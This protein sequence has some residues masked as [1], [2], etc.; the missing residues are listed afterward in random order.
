MNVQFNGKSRFDGDGGR[1]RLLDAIK[2]QRLALGR[3]ELVVALADAGEIQDVKVGAKLV[4]QDD[5][6]TDVYFILLG[7]FD[8][9]VNGVKVNE[10]G[11]GVH[12][13]EVAGID[14]G[15]KRSATL[16][17]TEPSVVFKLPD[18]QIRKL[19]KQHPEMFA[20][21]ALV[22][23]ER[24][25]ERNRLVAKCNEK[26][27]LLVLSS[28]EALGTAREVQSQFRGDDYVVRIWDQGV[29]KLSNY[30]IPSLERALHEVDFAIIIAQPDDTA[31]SRGKKK[32]VPRDNVT[33]EM[34]LAIGVLGLD[35]TIVLQPSDQRT[36]LASDAA[37]LTTARYRSADRLDAALGPACNDIRKHIGDLSVRR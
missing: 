16:V 33:F 17:A 5:V 27:H 29:F 24:L 18:T 2:V 1:D 3:D 25:I 8:V 10:R 14:A 12:V 15:Q 28:S 7:R 36:Q 20:V 30:P 31:V 21:M 37:G 19:A 4:Q 13:G 34:G 9:I 23:N 11:P 32:K 26:P 6:D 22:A 35:R